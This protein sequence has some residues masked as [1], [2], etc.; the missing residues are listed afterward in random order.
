MTNSIQKELRYETIHC[1][2]DI[3]NGRF[4]SKSMNNAE[5]TNFISIRDQ[6]PGNPKKPCELCY[7]IRNMTSCVMQECTLHVDGCRPIYNKGVC[8][9]VRY[10]C[11][12]LSNA[13][14]MHI[15]FFTPRNHKPIHLTNVF[16]LSIFSFL[17]CL[18]C[19]QLEMMICR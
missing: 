1:E 10:D 8:C 6:I 16:R 18:L 5:I 17:F 3:S 13:F 14:L 2:L 15:S 12:K 9:P 7:C 19:I 4:S 11:G